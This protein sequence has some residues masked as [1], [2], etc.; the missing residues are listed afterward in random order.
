L[1]PR[2][3]NKVVGV[4]SDARYRSITQPGEDLYVPYSQAGQPTN[5]VV[6]RGTRSAQDLTALVRRTL[7][8]IDSTQAIAGIATIGELIDRNAARHRF[9]MILLLW[10]GVCALV[11]AAM[12]VYSVVAEG[13]AVRRR[14]I[15]IKTVLGAG[16]PRLMREMVYR[17]LAFVLAGEAIG[18]G[19][20]ALSGN[21]GSELLYGVSARD[22]R[23]LGA[24]LGFLFVVSLVAALCPAWAATGRNPNDSL[25]EI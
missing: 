5:Y 12:G 2:G 10:F 21:A 23:V 16:K 20:I 25:R 3:G 11:L 24:V 18:L 14:E 19:C 7:A 8:G 13:V 4:A 22:P 6:I 1:G 9:N 17:A 15:A